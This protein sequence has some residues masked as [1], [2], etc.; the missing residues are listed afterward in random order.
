MSIQ[1]MK[2]EFYSKLALSLKNMAKI[3]LMP[4]MLMYVYIIHFNDVTYHKYKKPV[5][6]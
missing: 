3:M 6:N 5:Y 1:M 4:A 2:I